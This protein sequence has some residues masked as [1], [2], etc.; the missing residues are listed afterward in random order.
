[1]LAEDIEIGR[2]VYSK[3]GRDRGRP[4]LIWQIAGDKR[5]YVV[6][7]ILRRVHK[8]KLKNIIHLQTVNRG[9]PSIAER[10]NRGEKITDLEVRKI[11]ERLIKRQKA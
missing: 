7:G 4:F 8:P 5:V 2:L 9:D 3:A 1:M 10:L 11:I 6:D